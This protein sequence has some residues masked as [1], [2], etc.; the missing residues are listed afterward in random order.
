M[1]LQ[2]LSSAPL[3]TLLLCALFLLVLINLCIF[4]ANADVL[5]EIHESP[6]AFSLKEERRGAQKAA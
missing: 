5:R 6:A 1:T 4:Y 2:F 3:A